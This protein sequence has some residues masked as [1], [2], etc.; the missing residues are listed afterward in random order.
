VPRGARSS[1]KGARGASGKRAADGGPDGGDS[2]AG[3]RARSGAAGSTEAKVR[4]A[5]RS[6]TQRCRV[7]WR[8]FF[9][10]FLF[11]QRARRWRPCTEASLVGTALVVRPGLHEFQRVRG[12]KAASLWLGCRRPSGRPP[13]LPAPDGARARARQAAGG[14]GAARR[15]VAALRQAEGAPGRVPPGTLLLAQDPADLN[16]HWPVLV[17]AANDLP[18]AVAAG[19]CLPAC[20][21]FPLPLQEA[22]AS[23]RPEQA[24]PVL[25]IGT[26]ARSGGVRPTCAN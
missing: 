23:G 14:A 26:Q 4:R 9:F 6:R 21:D 2:P 1:T 20:A 12:T 10:E 8:S 19:G 13:R 22:C 7:S 25:I 15:V 18:R 24:L 3:K 11:L 17:A 16:R 5:V